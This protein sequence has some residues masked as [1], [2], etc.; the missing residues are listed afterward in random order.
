MKNKSAHPASI[1]LVILCALLLHAL[2]NSSGF[3]NWTQVLPDSPIRPVFSSISKAI[4]TVSTKIK[5][6]SIASC[7]KQ[8]FEPMTRNFELPEENQ[9]PSTDAPF[10]IISPGEFSSS[11]PLQVLIVGDSLAGLQTSTAFY[12]WARQHDWVDLDIEYKIGSSF[13]NESSKNWPRDVGGLLARKQYD[14]VAV[15]MGSNDSQSIILDDGTRLSPH[16]PEWTQVYD[17][18]VRQFMAQL[19][20]GTQE[21]YW[22]SVPPMRPNGNGYENRMVQ[23]NEHLHQLCNDYQNIQYLDMAKII[24]NSEG[25]YTDVQII[26]GKQRIVRQSDGIHPTFDGAML[27]VLHIE[28]AIRSRFSIQES[29]PNL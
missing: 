9:S 16:S 18:R 6:S 8:A 14:A 2:F 17:R 5:I 15:F 4:E 1:F 26:D 3:A 21:V 27:M 20:F 12:H 23:L 29:D 19:S 7:L 13:S 10:R 22:I 11:K 24:G 25:L 28:E